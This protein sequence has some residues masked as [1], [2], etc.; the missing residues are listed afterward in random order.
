MLFTINGWQ[1]SSK[2]SD[3][4]KE[5]HLTLENLSLERLSINCFN[6]LLLSTTPL[7]ITL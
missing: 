4:A 5:H 2:R 1:Y 7:A 6:K 3:D